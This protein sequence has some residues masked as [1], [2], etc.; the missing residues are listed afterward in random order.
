MARPTTKKGSTPRSKAQ[1]QTNDQENKWKG[2]INVKLTDD[3]M[4]A[5]EAAYDPSGF[6]EMFMWLVSYGKVSLAWNPK[7]KIYD[8][9][10]V[11][12]EEPRAG[13]GVSAR[14]SEPHFA[15]ANL[16]YKIN[17][18]WA[19]IVNSEPSEPRAMRG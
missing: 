1:T 13:Y 15:L 2:F 7:T 5:I 14:H 8:A 16:A 9:T 11:L 3:E 12:A 18:R 10:I 17:E 4:D 19:D 6:A